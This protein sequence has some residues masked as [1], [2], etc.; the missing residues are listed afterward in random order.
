MMKRISCKYSEYLFAPSNAVSGE[1]VETSDGFKCRLSYISTWNNEDGEY[2]DVFEN[3][4]QK[5]F[6]CSFHTIRSIWI[7]RLGFV[8]GFWN[9]VKM[10]KVS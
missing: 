3:L 2:D 5:Y 7:S 10:E 9:L 8:S 1:D 4:C 6:M